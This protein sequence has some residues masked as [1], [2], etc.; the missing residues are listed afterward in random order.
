MATRKDP[1]TNFNFIVELDGI[2]RAAFHEASGLD[3][4]IDIIEHREGGR[5]PGPILKFPGQV[6]FTNIM[7]KWGMADDTALYEWHKQWADGD[8]EAVRKNGSIVLLDRQGEEKARWNF[9][10]AW[11]CKWAGPSLSA[12]SADIAIESLELAHEGLARA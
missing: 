8:A 3:S 9:F 10:N 4:S 12:E 6:K 5:K 11:P 2:Q 1:Y 7:L